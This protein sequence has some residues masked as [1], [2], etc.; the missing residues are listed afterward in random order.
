MKIKNKNQDNGNSK[1]ILNQA[2]ENWVR[3]CL[4]SIKQKKELANQN[5]KTYEYSK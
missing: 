3:L 1:D 5:K 2:A 4:F